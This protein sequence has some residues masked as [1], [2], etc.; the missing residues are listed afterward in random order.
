MSRLPDSLGALAD[1]RFAWYFTA[2]TVS[3]AGS[4][5]APLALAFAV[6]HI[7]SSAS[8]LGQVL[9]VRTV[10]LIVFLLVGGVISDR[11]SRIGVLQLAHA[12]TFVTQGLAAMLV[13]TSHATLLQVTI[14]EGING[15]ASAFTMPA[16][17]GI[18]PL[19]VDHARLQQANALLSFSRS[20]LGV[21]GPA[22]AGALV[23]GV[24]PGWA[25]VADSLT[26]L[27]AIPCL[28]KVRIPHTAMV[29]RSSMLTELREGWTEF[30]SREWL[31]VIVLLAGVTNAIYTGAI[32]VLGPLTAEQTPAIGE[33]GW[34]LIL[35]AGALGTV[36]M[37]LIMLRLR[38]KHPLRAGVV[39][40]SVAAVP[41]GMLG[42]WPVLAPL[43]IAFL[44][45]GAGLE[46]FGVGWSTALHEHIPDAALSRVSSYDMLGSFV[47]IPVG[48]FLYGWL[49]AGVD[50]TLL[51]TISAVVF[52]LV[53]LSALLSRDVRTLGHRASPTVVDRGASLGS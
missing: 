46:M 13:I 10:A 42:L 26:F 15:A 11:F 24:G 9:G 43:M 39:A 38:L 22:I 36:V 18:V 14:I 16:M 8:A 1:R 32:G 4:T 29:P 17:M 37:T 52:A 49:A 48:T 51:L 53:M 27:L 21:T 31:W 30:R 7:D 40:V 12:L 25:L 20:A 2:R 44:L 35:S 41:I 23:A 34:G 28:A 33:N 47:A 45:G 50:P 19:V 5:M 3:T 6:L